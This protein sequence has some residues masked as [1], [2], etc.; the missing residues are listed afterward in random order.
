[1]LGISSV[2]ASWGSTG[3]THARGGISLLVSLAL[4]VAPTQVN[5]EI[6][7][8]PDGIETLHPGKG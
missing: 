6:T 5:Q 7:D 1:M 8:A 2:E 4:R 3:W